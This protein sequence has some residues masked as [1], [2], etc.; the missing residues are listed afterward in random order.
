M[1]N[2]DPVALLTLTFKRIANPWPSAELDALML[3]HYN[4]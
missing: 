2:V 3:W 1:N 4:A